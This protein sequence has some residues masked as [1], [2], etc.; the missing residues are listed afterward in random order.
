MSE[1]EKV[2]ENRLRRKAGRQG[3]QLLKS[4]RRDPDAMDYG[5]YALADVSTNG[6]VFGFGTFGFEASLDDI[7]AFLSP[8]GGDA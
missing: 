2:R 3:L 8:D 4:R 6:A 1:N 7:E 5:C